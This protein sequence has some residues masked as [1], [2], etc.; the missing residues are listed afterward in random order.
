MSQPRLREGYC[1]ILE[2]IRRIESQSGPE[3]EGWMAKQ[4]VR[5]LDLL[6]QQ[7]TVAQRLCKQCGL[8]EGPM[9]SGEDG[10]FQA[11][12]EA[13][14]IRLH[15]QATA[16]CLRQVRHYR[17]AGKTLETLWKDWQAHRTGT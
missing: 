1:G 11:M 12:L 4:G 13:A 6:K 2:S 5:W 10:R 7:L 8:T 16:Y 15:R 17:R 14:E 9:N 3:E